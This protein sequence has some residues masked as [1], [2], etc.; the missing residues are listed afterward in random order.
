MSAEA[1]S[2]SEISVDKDNLYREET[3]TDLKVATIRR[4][5]PIRPDGSDDPSREP[6]FVGVTQLMSQ[7]GPVPVSCPIEAAT[8]EEA[9]QRFPEAVNEAVERLIEE[10]REIQRQEASRIVVPSG[11]PPGPGGPLGGGGGKIIP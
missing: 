11:M 7:A 5:L 1:K 9:M 8:L 4:L 3:F 6:L 2:I 10:A